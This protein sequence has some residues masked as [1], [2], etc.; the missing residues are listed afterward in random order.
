MMNE[1]IFDDK[2]YLTFTPNDDNF[3]CFS[4]LTDDINS[5]VCLTEN[6]DCGYIIK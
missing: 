1:H 6:I 2:Y 5:T 4:S 3:I